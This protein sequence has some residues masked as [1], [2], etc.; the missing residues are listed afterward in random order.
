MKRTFSMLMV[1]VAFVG[2]ATGCSKEE[3]TQVSRVDGNLQN[4]ES[5]PSDVGGGM[6]PGGFGGGGPGDAGGGGAAF[7]N[8]QDANKDGRLT[9][10]ELSGRLADRLEELDTDG[11]GA[12][13]PEEYGAGMQGSGAGGGPGGFGGGRGGP[14]G[15]GGGFDPSAIFDRRDE[16]EDG[17]LTGDELSGRLADRAEELDKDSDGAVSREEFEEGMQS[18][19]AGGGGGGRG[20][21]A[22]GGFGRG[23]RGPDNRPKRPARPEFD[24]GISDE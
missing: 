23:A 10:D 8:R 19:F 1:G 15:G 11:D 17:K 21:G 14:G 3:T 6:A 13:S 12:I 4:D 2:F 22:G 7:F 20:P 9:G 16:N 18:M 5:Q 24:E